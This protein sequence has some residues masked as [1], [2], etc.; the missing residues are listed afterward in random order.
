MGLLLLLA[1]V[2][3]LP[4]HA[5]ALPSHYAAEAIEARVIDAETKK[6]L[7]GV[8]VVAHW[9]LYEGT[10]GGRIPVG[11]LMV[12]ETVTDSNGHF[13]FPAWGPKPRER[14]FLDEADPELLFFK[15]G[16]EYRRLTNPVR[17]K[18]NKDAL[19]RSQWNGR[20]IPLKRFT[21]TLEEYARH[22]RSLSL[23]WAYTG[24]ECEWKE[25]PRMVLAAHEQA[26]TFKKHRIVTSLYT[27]DN[28][29]PYE[30]YPDKCGAR[31]YFTEYRP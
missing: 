3:A 12:L 8:I 29:V 27:I 14:G 16:H 28:L 1:L 10:V 31:E 20:T 2:G 6:P 7:E 4:A 17:S 5:T 15:S 18:V 9:Q 23:S 24:N 11:Q 25:M 21:G 22:L 13:Q 19:R 26:M 30:G